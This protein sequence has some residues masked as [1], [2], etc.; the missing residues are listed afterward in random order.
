MK[1]YSMEDI[2]NKYSRIPVLRINNFADNI[3]KKLT[4]ATKVSSLFQLTPK[5]HYYPFAIDAI[6][7]TILSYPSL[8]APQQV[9]IQK[10]KNKSPRN[11]IFTLRFSKEKINQEEAN[12]V[13]GE[14]V[15]DDYNFDFDLLHIDNVM[16]GNNW[17]YDNPSVAT[18]IDEIEFYKWKYP[19]PVYF[20][21]K[22]GNYQEL[23]FYAPYGTGLFPVII[24]GLFDFPVYQACNDLQGQKRMVLVDDQWNP[25]YLSGMSEESLNQLISIAI[26]EFLKS[27]GMI[28]SINQ[29]MVIMKN[30]AMNN[31]QRIQQRPSVS[32]I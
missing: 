24:T 11:G 4:I 8:V 13:A 12:Y 30:E 31:L 25:E 5:S 16:V 15:Y 2:N 29:Q 27:I 6:R 20:F 10:A 23:S 17:D 1:N 9:T 19:N 28:D 32:F 26:P 21:K 22:F 18:R 14:I 3:V 7:A